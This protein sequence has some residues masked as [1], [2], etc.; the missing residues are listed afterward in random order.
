MAITHRYSPEH[1]AERS[2]RIDERF[3]FGAVRTNTPE[4]E[5][6]KQGLI[7]RY[8]DMKRAV[9]FYEALDVIK[10]FQPFKPDSSEPV[11]PASP[12]KQFPRA[13]LMFVAEELGFKGEEK[14]VLFWTAVG[15]FVDTGFGADAVI[16][17][18]DKRCRPSCFVP[19][20]VTLYT[21]KVAEKEKVGNKV[22]IQGMIPDPIDNK[23]EYDDKVREIG[24]QVVEKVRA[25][26]ITQ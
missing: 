9:P 12:V 13:L 10:R 23:K 19:L 7:Q 3:V 4:Y 1:F 22:V 26:M 24:R 15:S 21:G 25:Q 16:E 6:E 18:V 2:G 20:D 17:I 5:Q 14:S 11:D 8:R